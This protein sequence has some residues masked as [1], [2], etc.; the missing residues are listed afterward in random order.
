MQASRG[1]H[2]PAL[3]TTNRCVKTRFEVPCRTFAE[4]P[5]LRSTGFAGLEL[6]PPTA[7]PSRAPTD[8]MGTASRMAGQLIAN[9]RTERQ[10]WPA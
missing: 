8:A 10:Q 5:G 7:P 9:L 2:R 3:P 6:T 4:R 1:Y